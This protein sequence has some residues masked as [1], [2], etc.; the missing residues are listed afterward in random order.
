[1]KKRDLVV[2]KKILQET[3][4]IAKMVCGISESDFI[5]NEEK[6]RAVCM[7]LINIGELVKNL[8][9]EFRVQNVNIPWKKIAGMRDI[10]AHGYF[11]LKM[12]DIWQTVQSDVPVLK[13]QIADLIN[14]DSTLH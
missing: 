10:A 3:N 2:L 12:T 6:Q 7:T 13:N 5:A 4:E 14:A 8:S 1:M 11:T 9:N